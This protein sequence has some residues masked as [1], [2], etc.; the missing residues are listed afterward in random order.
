MIFYLVPVYCLYALGVS[1]HAHIHAFTDMGSSNYETLLTGC[2]QQ[3]SP[4]TMTLGTADYI[5]MS[6]CKKEVTPLLLHWSYVFL[7]LNH[8]Y[9]YSTPSTDDYHSPQEEMTAWVL[10]MM[11]E[12]MQWWK[13]LSAFKHFVYC[14][15][16]CGVCCMGIRHKICIE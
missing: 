16:G 4:F 10:I 9:V 5:L 11:D 12:T 8:W 1:Y 13:A 15:S 3:D 6:W 7:A 2:A 14:L